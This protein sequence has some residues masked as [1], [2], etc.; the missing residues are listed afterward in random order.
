MGYILSPEAADRLIAS[1]ADDCLVFAP[2]RFV[3][4][5]VF[6]DLDCI[7]Y[8]EVKTAGEIVF[9]QKSDYSFKEILTPVC[10]ALFYFTE[11]QIK[12]A[13]APEKGAVVFLRSCDLHAVK[14]L[15]DIFLNNGEEDYYYRRLRDRV[16]FVVMGCSKA[17]DSCFCV[18]MGTNVPEGY[19]MSM[20]PAEGVFAIDCRDAE[21]DELL[22]GLADR[23]CD[24]EPSHVEETKTRVKIPEGLTQDVMRSK[25]WDEYDGRCIACGRC[26]FVCPTCTCYT[27]QDLFYTENGHV[28][29]RRRVQASCMVDGF[30]DVAGGGSYRKKNGERM[31]FKTLHKA[32]DYKQRFGYQMCVGCG[33][34]DDVCPEYIS[35]SRILNRLGDMMEEVNTDAE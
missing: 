3:G 27:M 7:R 12:E 8:G 14:R 15:D 6:S 26:N 33:R 19:N 22:G 5:A 28:G 4:G 13:D 34:C 24:V 32:L 35:F 16:K 9:D 23:K 1:L 18:D 2:K 21:L 17:F 31:R 29:E 11:D 30:T 20:E 25:I 10:Q